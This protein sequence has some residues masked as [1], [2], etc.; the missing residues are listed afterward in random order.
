MVGWNPSHGRRLEM[1]GMGEK[2]ESTPS[3][4]L[5]VGFHMVK[6]LSTRSLETES[7]LSYKVVPIASSLDLH[8]NHE[9]GV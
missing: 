1:L 7:F 8:I 9:T 2:N 3:V 4:S 6:N 5:V